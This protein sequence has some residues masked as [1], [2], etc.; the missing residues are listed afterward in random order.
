MAKLTMDR[1]INEVLTDDKKDGPCTSLSCVHKENGRDTEVYSVLIKEGAKF[2]TIELAELFKRKAENH[3]QGLPGHQQFF[4]HAK[5]KGRSEYEAR[6]PFAV[7]G[8][9]DLA[10]GM[11][12]AP[13]AEGRV[14]QKM[15]Q[16][17]FGHQFWAKMI[18]NHFE[19]LNDRL[20]E[21]AKERKELRQENRDATDLFKNM[22]FESASKNH[23]YEMEKLK[24]QR[25]NMF[26]DQAAKLGP[27][28]I[29][30]LTGKEIIPQST[31]DT[32]LID[33]VLE[34]LTPD[35]VQ[36]LQSIFPPQVMGL[37]MARAKTHFEKKLAAEQ[38]A[39]SAMEGRRDP[40]LDS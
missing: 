26:Y 30:A 13:T 12:E 3:V 38:A 28:V 22:L 24:Y 20:T 8:G 1:W 15:R 32:S 6:L 34:T 18:F 25:E 31:A 14:S 35:K 9:T 29:N 10:H 2:D 36:V 39:A 11:T 23:Q 17:E 27:S 7:D 4:L 21:D 19:L 16:D 40:A 37:V 33:A 5:Y